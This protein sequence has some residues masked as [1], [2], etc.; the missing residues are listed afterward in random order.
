MFL[1]FAKFYHKLIKDYL[2][3]MLPLTQLIQKNQPFIWN[4]SANST[5]KG[6]KQACTCAPILL[7][8]DRVKRCHGK[9]ERECV[10]KTRGS[11]KKVV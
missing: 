5:F 9:N 8:V 6:L 11:P 10:K 4:T 2:K 7:H 1:G 3:I